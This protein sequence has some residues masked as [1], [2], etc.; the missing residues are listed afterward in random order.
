MTSFFLM[1]DNISLCKYAIFSFGGGRGG[2][3]VHIYNASTLLLEPH[4]WFNFCS[5]YFGDESS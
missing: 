5:V 2:M 1:Y 3:G 4:L